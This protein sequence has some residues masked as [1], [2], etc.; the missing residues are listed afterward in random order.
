MGPLSGI[1]VAPQV[2]AA[3]RLFVALRARRWSAELA[4]DAAL[5]V[6]RRERDGSG[7][8][9]SAAGT[10]LAGCA[11]MSVVASCLV[12]RLGWLH[13]RGVG[14]DV[15]GAGSAYFG[16]MGLRLGASKDVGRFILGVYAEGLAMLSN[17]EVVQ[18]DVVVWTVPRIGAF[19]GI[20]VAFLIF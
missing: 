3:G 8:T 12:G 10:S 20:D 2:T 9:V 19:I 14:I 13:A 15:P 6:T 5:P 17:W 16:Q 1:G 11:Q 4:A 7:I 18:N